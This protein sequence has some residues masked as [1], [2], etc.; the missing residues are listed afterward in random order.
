VFEAHGEDGS[1]PDVEPDVLELIKAIGD[2]LCGCTCSRSA[3]VRINIS[4]ALRA[5]Y[6]QPCEQVGQRCW[7]EFVWDAI[8][9]GCRNVFLGPWHQGYRDAITASGDVAIALE[10]APADGL[11]IDYVAPAAICILDASTST[12][13][14]RVRATALRESLL[15]AYVR[16]A[17]HRSANHYDW[18]RE[19]HAAFGAA[20]LR[21]AELE[22]PAVLLGNIHML[23]NS[24]GALAELLEALLSAATYEARFVAVLG[25]VWPELMP[26]GLASAA[27]D[28]AR[29]DHLRLDT[30][31]RNLVPSPK[32]FGFIEN[33]DAVLAHA[34]S[35]WFSLGTVEKHIDR[36][37]Q[38]AKGKVFAVDSLVGFLESQKIQDQASVGIEWVHRLVVEEDRSASTCG[39]LL[40]RW[41]RD[42]RSSRLLSPIGSR[43]YRAIV[44]A[45]VLGNFSGA[46]DLQ[47]LDE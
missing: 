19:Q 31:L 5:T 29:E 21:C 41:L 1:P 17:R 22:G 46:R 11:I 10:E 20:L 18:R 2:A 32:P 42:I 15:R 7:H 24:V 37:L 47:R 12:A 4:Q 28:E 35:H 14:L 44:D 39:F 40:V 33:T 16:A 34:R 27:S 3:E 6:N 45:L 13:C 8:E 38:L 26:I 9:A 25:N 30:L 43:Q 36:W 23:K